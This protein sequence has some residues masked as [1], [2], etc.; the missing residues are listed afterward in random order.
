LSA[1]VVRDA[2]PGDADAMGVIHVRAWQAAYRDAM[3]DAYL[4]GLNAADRAQMWRDGIA[5]RP[6]RPP[7][8]AL[9]DDVVVGHAAC[10]PTDD[11]E[12]AGELYSINV[13][14]DH[15][16]SGAG[17]ALIAE[18]H[19]RLAR[20]H[21]VAVLWV[22]PANA[23]ARRFYEREGWL[24]DGAERTA[25]VLGVTVPEVRYRKHLN[26]ATTPP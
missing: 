18:V 26:A 3:P 15:W 21:D 24:V 2:T 20:D 23:R 19:E 4:D 5:R 6:E 11:P 1:I 12:G 22:V 25:E 8:V 10:G 7:L 17:K 14:P 16:G 13:D 9:I